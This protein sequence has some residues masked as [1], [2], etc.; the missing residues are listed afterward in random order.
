MLQLFSESRH[1]AAA[2]SSFADVNLSSYFEK[3]IGTDPIL[4]DSPPGKREDVATGVNRIRGLEIKK[5][6]YVYSIG[7]AALTTHT[8]DLHQTTYANN[9]A[10]SVSST[11]GGTLTGTLATA[12][13]ANPYVTAITIGTPY[14]IGANT[15]LI[16]D[17][18]EVT[19]VF[20]ATSAYDIYGLFVDYNYVL[21]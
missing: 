13:Q 10:V 19:L 14:V 2:D 6:Q 21:L 4:T 15:D 1:T 12:T 20:A 17:Y 18:F 8:Y 11:I 3:K 5:L 9:V 16:G 7:T